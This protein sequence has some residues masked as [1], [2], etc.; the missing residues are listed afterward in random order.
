MAT[1]IAEADSYAGFGSAGKYFAYFGLAA[2]AVGLTG[3]AAMHGLLPGLQPAD[4]GSQLL[5]VAMEWIGGGLFGLMAMCVLGSLI[6]SSK[7]RGTVVVDD[8]GVTR[9]IGE[10]SRMLRWVEMEGF[11]VTPISAGI[12]LIPREG[13][14]T[15]VIPRFLDDYRG[16]VAE[17][18]AKGAKLLPPDNAQVRR[19]MRKRRTWQ[20]MSA[21]YISTVGFAMAYNPGD[22]HAVRWAGLA[23]CVGYSAWLLLF[24]D[25]ALEDHGWVRWFGGA[26]LAGMLVWLVRHIMHTW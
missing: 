18:K 1:Y 5:L 15:I 10:R 19:A 22:A 7:S 9:E 6:A 20:Q 14:R 26:V 21:G 8:L 13:R 17:I 11:V 12:T 2:G 25:F 4:A 3:W 16:C 24:E 23:A